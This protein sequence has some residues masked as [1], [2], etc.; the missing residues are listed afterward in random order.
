MEQL[1]YREA[2]DEHQLTVLILIPGTFRGRETFDQVLLQNR[3]SRAVSGVVHVCF[4]G[5]V[6]G[7]PDVGRN[8]AASPYVDIPLFF[9]ASIE[10]SENIVVRLLVEGS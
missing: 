4:W 10:R 6:A 5:G 8:R 9:A 2:L 1:V 7:R 3:T